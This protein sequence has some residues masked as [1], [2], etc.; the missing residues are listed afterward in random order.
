M[1]EVKERVPFLT[2]PTFYPSRFSLSLPVPPVLR[3][4]RIL[5]D[6]IRNMRQLVDSNTWENTGVDT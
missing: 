2:H 5:K 4:L 6:D 3:R 1:E